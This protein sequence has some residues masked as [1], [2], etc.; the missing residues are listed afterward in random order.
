[1]NRSQR[2]FV[3]AQQ[4]ELDWTGKGMGWDG[5]GMGMGMG[6]KARGSQPG[7]LLLAVDQVPRHV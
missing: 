4:W 1:M 2:S 3:C 5:M 7:R 6:K